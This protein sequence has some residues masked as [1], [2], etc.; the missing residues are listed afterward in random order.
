MGSTSTTSNR[1]DG[2]FGASAADLR[3]SS[4][5]AVGGFKFPESCAYDAKANVLYVGNFGG[6]KPDAA[7]KDGLG[8]LSRVDYETTSAA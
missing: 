8:Y 1:T 3:V 6:D 2:A 4:D 5:Q 7:A